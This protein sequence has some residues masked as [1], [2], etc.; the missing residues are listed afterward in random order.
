M[1]T[2]THMCTHTRPHKSTYTYV[3]W[4][5]LNYQLGLR[6]ALSSTMWPLDMNMWVGAA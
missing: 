3:Q 2:H 5:T 1:H 6:L 4:Y